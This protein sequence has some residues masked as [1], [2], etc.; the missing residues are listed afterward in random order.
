MTAHATHSVQRRLTLVAIISGVIVLALV[1]VAAILLSYRI[2]P[3]PDNAM[4]I[5]DEER[6]TYASSPCVL[7][8]HLDRELIT[9]RAEIADQTK[10]LE[11]QTYANERKISDVNDGSWARDTACNFAAGFDQIVTTWMQL[12]GYRSRWAEDGQWRW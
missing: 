5:V 3:P 8:N 2:L 12:T 1:G 10:P 11:L 4:V 7:F 9:N 6:K